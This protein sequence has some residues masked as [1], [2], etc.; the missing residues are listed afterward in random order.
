MGHERQRPPSYDDILAL[1]E[2]LV[3]E[4]L[5]GELVVSPRPATHHANAA[6]GIVSDVGGPFQRDPGG[7]GGW[8]ILPDPEL[9]L[10]SG[11]V[12]V[13][14]L[15]GWRRE[16]MSTLPNVAAVELA[17]DWVCEIVSP[18]TQRH[19]RGKKRRIYARE[20]VTH[21]WI[22]DPIARSLELLRLENRRYFVVET[23]EED[24]KVRAEP[25]DAVE[26]EISRWWPPEAAP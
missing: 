25:F 17:P 5:D 10:R 2:H 8:W 20:G 6:A 26:I 19:D 12:V 18:R 14:D 3:G 23:Y 1:P 9:H 22:V 21:Y 4:I 16:R 15:A 7:P 11:N 13:P 24:E